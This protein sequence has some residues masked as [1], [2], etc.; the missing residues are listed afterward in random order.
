MSTQIKRTR[1]LITLIVG[2]LLVSG[3]LLAIKIAK[4]YRPNLSKLTLTGTGLLSATSYPKSAQVYINDRLT[5]VTD[6]TLY[7][8]P[9]DYEIKII[10]TG[11]HSWT[12]TLPIKSELVSTTDARLFPSIPSI[13]P[14][15][16]YLA[17]KPAVS[18]DG[19]KLAYLLTGSPFPTDNGVYILS[20]ANNLL[21]GNQIIQITDSSTFDYTK[22]E[23]LW[24]PDGS[25][26]LAV[27]HD[28]NKVTASHLLNPRTMNQAKS[29]T[30]STIRLPL[31]LKEWQTQLAT[32][33][34]NNLDRLPDEMAKVAT[35]SAVNV[36]FSPD[37]EKMLYTATTSQ[38]LPTFLINTLPS[39]NPS[40]QERKLEA[41]KIYV[42]DLK[43]DSNFA[44]K[45]AKSKS[46][47]PVTLITTPLLA[48]PAPLPAITAPAVGGTPTIASA[49]GGSRQA[50]KNTK[51]AEVENLIR[52]IAQIKGQTDPLST[53][54]LTWYSTSRHLLISNED[55]VS[56]VEYDDNNL[57][58]IFAATISGGFSIA[59]PDGSHLTILTNFNQKPEIFNLLSL[60]LK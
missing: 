33:N 40:K 59:S 50:G 36:Y 20:L 37:R 54:N 11:F 16:F 29:L 35:A 55:G 2:L 17:A 8:T 5:T 25:Q 47:T 38:E 32:I 12:K 21:L 56:V 31:I 19:N 57:T 42:Y 45:E 39:I 18:P 60:D 30:D 27:F 10:K 52:Q 41:G 3:T 15:T 13:T 24:S 34:Q 6:D 58:P 46:T 4:G 48:S 28:D 26:V 44:I 1:L 9:N 53:Q 14:I 7:L 22:A 43:E 51:S 23:L 49:R